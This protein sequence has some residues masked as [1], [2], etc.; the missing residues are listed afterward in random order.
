MI[1]PDA[2]LD[3]V[4]T[5]F[6][7]HPPATVNE[8]RAKMAELTGITRS[9]T[10]VREWMKRCGMRCR[11]IGVLPAKGDPDTQA[12]YQNRAAVEVCQKA[13]LVRQVLP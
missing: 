1:Q 11:K 8:A 6:R 12:A 2:V 10:Q 4:L 9:P 13:V 7:Q 3:Q 5:Y